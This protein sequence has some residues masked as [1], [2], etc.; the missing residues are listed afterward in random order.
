VSKTP[1]ELESAMMLQAE[2]IAELEAETQRLREALGVDAV[3]VENGPELQRDANGRPYITDSA[4][5]RIKSLVALIERLQSLYQVEICTVDCDTIAF[6]DLKRRDDWGE[7]Y[8]VYDAGIFNT[9][10]NVGVFRLGELVFDDFLW[11]ED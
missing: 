2:R 4:K 6:R 9:S 8:E 3:R 1:E 11:W 5:T 10:N 7:G